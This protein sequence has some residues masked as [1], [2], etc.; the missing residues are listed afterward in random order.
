MVAPLLSMDAD[1]DL[2]PNKE[3]DDGPNYGF[4]EKMEGTRDASLRNLQTVQEQNDSEFAIVHSST[5]TA[6]KDG[7]VV[8]VFLKPSLIPFLDEYPGLLLSLL[9]TQVV[10]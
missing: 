1:S 4:G 10:V 6:G 7:C 2:F 5:L 3:V 8:L 9:G